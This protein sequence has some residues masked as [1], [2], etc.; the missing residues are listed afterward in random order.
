[1]YEAKEL[2]RAVVSI[3]QIRTVIKTFKQNLFTEIFP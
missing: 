2:D 1:M 3:D